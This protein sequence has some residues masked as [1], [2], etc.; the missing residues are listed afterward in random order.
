LVFGQKVATNSIASYICRENCK[1]QSPN[2]NGVEWNIIILNNYIIIA[3][4]F[5]NLVSF[6]TFQNRL[7]NCFEQFKN[8]T[9][10]IERMKSLG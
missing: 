5:G 8:Q 4:S 3:Q 10:S 1:N 7:S 2:I 6:L 9:I